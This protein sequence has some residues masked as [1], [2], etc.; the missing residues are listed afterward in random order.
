MILLL[1]FIAGMVIDGLLIV[2]YKAIVKPD[3]LL[4][5]ILSG[6]IT[7]INVFVLIHLVRYDSGTNMLAYILGNVA[8]TYLLIG[9]KHA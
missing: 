1:Y 6:L 3:R 9:E 7:F 2:Y 5:A 8:A 4:G